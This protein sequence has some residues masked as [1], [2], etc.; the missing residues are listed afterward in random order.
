[1]SN[2][3]IGSD[4][5]D[6]LTRNSE[7]IATRKRVVHPDY[8]RKTVKN[9]FMIVAL[10]SVTTKVPPRKFAKLDDGKSSL[11]NGEPLTIVGYGATNKRGDNFPSALK[12]ANTSFVPHDICV[13]K[14]YP[15]WLFGRDYV[16]EATMLCSYHPVN[17]FCYGDSGGPLLNQ[18]QIQVGVVSWMTGGNCAH[19]EYANVRY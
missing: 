13:R 8:D 9:D 7:Q 11:T 16:D 19:R 6:R 15:A 14:Y 10:K 17:A 3:T 2:V 18:N 5:S 4:R 12:E 1:M